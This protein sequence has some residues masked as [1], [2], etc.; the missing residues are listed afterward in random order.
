[1]IWQHLYK[2][3]IRHP[4]SPGQTA[5]RMLALRP[6]A[7]EDSCARRQTIKIEPIKTARVQL[8]IECLRVI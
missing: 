3:G 7:N 6:A 2:L 8:S 4:R 1:M 5:S